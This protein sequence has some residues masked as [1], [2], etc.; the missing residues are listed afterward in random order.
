MIA[1]AAVVVL[2]LVAAATLRADINPDPIHLI[3]YL[4]GETE[5]QD[6]TWPKIQAALARQ[7]RPGERPIRLVYVGETDQRLPK[8]LDEL[9][10]AVASPA[11]FAVIAP[12]AE[13]ASAV[14]ASGHSVVFASYFDPVRIGL[15]ASAARPGG[16]MTGVSL[17]DDLDAKRV[18][19]LQEAM[20]GTLHR[21][22]VLTDKP[23]SEV[24]GG[25][26]PMRDH[27]AA[28][29]IALEERWA[30]SADT[31][32]AAL[33]KPTDAEA[34]YIPRSFLAAR[35]Q[36]RIAGHLRDR[37][38]WAMFTMEGE[39]AD[40]GQMAYV[41][42]TG[43]VWDAL[44]SLAL[45]VVEGESP[46][47]IPIERPKRYVLVVRVGGPQPRPAAAFVSRADRVVAND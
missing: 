17:A 40:G 11:R 15:V 33:A 30:D 43:F 28:H 3:A 9:S 37:G 38:A 2:G 32:E 26:Q 36:K 19:L 20:G 35:F 31:L 41:Q 27:C 7:S 6:S 16:Q 44:A 45:R 46:A 1:R 8:R 34:W 29:G 4:G 13:A 10:R 14:K 18:D 21:L 22:L 47:L 12:S 42:D 25:A 5:A 23:W 39:V 24:A